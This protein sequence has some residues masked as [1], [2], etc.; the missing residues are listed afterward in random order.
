MLLYDVIKGDHTAF[1]HEE[2][3]EV[4]WKIIEKIREKKHLMYIYKK[5]SDGPKECEDFFK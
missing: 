1:L 2:E 4:S 5:R 3:V